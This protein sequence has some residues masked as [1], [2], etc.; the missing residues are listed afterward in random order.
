VSNPSDKDIVRIIPLGGLDEIGKNMTAIEYRDE[1]V[2]I[3]CGLKFPED[4]MLGIDSVIP[5]V[6]FLKNNLHKVNGFFITHGHEDH[7]GALPH[8]LKEVNVPVYS[9]RLTLG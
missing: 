3:D 7:I 8:I 6:T 2:V 1:I 5:D 9:T 4:E